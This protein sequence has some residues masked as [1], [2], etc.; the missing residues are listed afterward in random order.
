MAQSGRLG[1]IGKI[2]PEA[3]PF[4]V[5]RCT[6]RWLRRLRLTGMVKLGALPSVWLGG[7]IWRFC[8]MC[9]GLL[10]LLL[11]LFLRVCGGA[12]GSGSL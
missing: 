3:R 1:L 11:A 4:S 8:R 2:V 7:Y 12:S 5:L 9:P 10:G 6:R